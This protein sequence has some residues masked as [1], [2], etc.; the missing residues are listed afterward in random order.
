LATNA[1][2]ND[3][4]KNV[5]YIKNLDE[6]LEADREDCALIINSKSDANY[7]VENAKNYSI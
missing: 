7:T 1:E 2:L 6:F 4:S 3:Q 5:S